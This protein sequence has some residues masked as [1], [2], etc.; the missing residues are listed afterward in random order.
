MGP[1]C[2]AVRYAVGQ[3][4]LLPTSHVN[5]PRGGGEQRGTRAGQ[6]AFRHRTPG[7]KIVFAG[8]APSCEFVRRQVEGYFPH[9]GTCLL[10][11]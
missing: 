8:G 3:V 7:K 1:S 5:V 6:P 4:E 10:S 9:V 11:V 2:T